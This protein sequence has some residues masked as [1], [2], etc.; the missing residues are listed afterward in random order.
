MHTAGKNCR[1]GF[2]PAASSGAQAVV[3][4]PSNDGGI[5]LN[6]VT[7]AQNPIYIGKPYSYDISARA[8]TLGDISTQVSSQM[9][10]YVSKTD[11][12]PS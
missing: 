8:A 2:G 4:S 5:I 6:G 12:V 9:S 11:I 1:I 3:L 7:F 10:S